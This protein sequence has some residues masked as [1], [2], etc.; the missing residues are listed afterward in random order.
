MK[1][2][3]GRNY[4]LTSGVR[5]LYEQMAFKPEVSSGPA[6]LACGRVKAASGAGARFWKMAAL[7]GVFFEN[8]PVCP[9]RHRRGR[10][11][12]ARIMTFPDTCKIQPQGRGRGAAQAPRLRGHPMGI[13]SELGRK[14][15]LTGP[16]RFATVGTK[17]ADF[18]GF[19]AEKWGNDARPT[20]KKNAIDRP[21][22]LVTAAA[23]HDIS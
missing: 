9:V 7:P 17:M 1:L 11:R 5:T 16:R 20:T 4:L 6:R 10:T 22:C 21:V 15:G 18:R 19:K 14:T 2:C 8:G 12:S 13:I 3:A 23:G